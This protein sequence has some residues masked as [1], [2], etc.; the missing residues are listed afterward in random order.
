[1]TEKVT[2]RL[3]FGDVEF[4]VSGPENFVKDT[5][6]QFIPSADVVVKL[7]ETAAK[8]VSTNR[9][10]FP[11]DCAQPQSQPKI[12][13]SFGEYLKI[14]KGNAKPIGDRLE[15]ALAFLMIEKDMPTVH[16]DEVWQ[17][18][19]DSKVASQYKA[20]DVARFKKRHNVKS[21]QPT[22]HLMLDDERLLEIKSMVSNI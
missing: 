17:L 22:G 20:R 21:V 8:S 6:K 14:S 11:D 4:E 15:L 16:C 10:T 7:F 2:L 19:L 12:Q 1:M 13:L 5:H 18:L 3:R 9:D